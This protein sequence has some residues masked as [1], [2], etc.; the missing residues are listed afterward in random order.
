MTICPSANCSSASS[1]YVLSPSTASSF[2]LSNLTAGTTGA[3]LGSAG[4]DGVSGASAFAAPVGAGRSAGFSFEDAD[5]P[6][7]GAF[8]APTLRAGIA[9]PAVTFGAG[10]TTGKDVG[11]PAGGTGATGRGASCG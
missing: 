6:A 5:P 11:T 7:S 3:G 1:S 9:G 2:S 10:P 8:A 4:V